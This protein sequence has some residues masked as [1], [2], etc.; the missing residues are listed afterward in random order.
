VS[1]DE[2]YVMK[3]EEELFGKKVEEFPWINAQKK[4]DRKLMK[5]GFV[6]RTGNTADDSDGV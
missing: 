1:K 3:L 4:S 5:V 2:S 6:P